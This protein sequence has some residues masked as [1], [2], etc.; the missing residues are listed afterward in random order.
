MKDVNIT[1]SWPQDPFPAGASLW[2]QMVGRLTGYGESRYQF[3][4]D[5]F[6]PH[7]ILKG[8]GTVRTSGGEWLV[9]PGDMFTLW[10]GVSIEYFEEPATPWE[11]LWIHLVGPGAQEYVRACGFTKETPILKAAKPSAVSERLAFIHEA[12]E[13]RVQADVYTV[14]A[15]L[16][17]LPLFCVAAVGERSPIADPRR[18]LVV[19]VA[20]TL[21]A[22]LHTSLSV[23]ELSSMFNVS[24]VTLFRAFH[25]TMGISPFDYLERQR[26]AKAVQLLSDTDHPVDFVAKA[27]GY[28]NPKYFMSRFKEA[29]GMTPTT[30]RFAHHKKK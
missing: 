25:E 7:I 8:R 5:Y 12:F 17:E 3:L 29:K 22:L 26:M 28:A 24:R 23:K 27:C 2:P 9:G 20:A 13:N 4:P 15:R 19:R 21:E 14:L 16:Y 1:R 10:P 30:F 6:C 18:D 11:Y